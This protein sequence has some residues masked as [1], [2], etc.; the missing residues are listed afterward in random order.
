MANNHT[1]EITTSANLSDEQLK[2]VEDAASEA[3]SEAES[4]QQPPDNLNDDEREAWYNQHSVTI[5]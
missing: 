2:A 3:V 4:Q 5:S 1:I